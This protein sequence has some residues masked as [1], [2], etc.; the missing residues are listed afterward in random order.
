MDK[1]IFLFLNNRG[2]I[3]EEDMCMDNTYTYNRYNN[4]L[5][6]CNRYY[7]TYCNDL[8]QRGYTSPSKKS[9]GF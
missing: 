5:Y 7:Y 3:C 2:E 9:D 8:K 1:L 4:C 6:E